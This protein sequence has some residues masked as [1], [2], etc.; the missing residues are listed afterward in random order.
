MVLLEIPGLI[1]GHIEAGAAEVIF[2]FAFADT[3][4]IAAV[5]EALALPRQ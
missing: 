4:G 5:G 3:A 2:S 1:A